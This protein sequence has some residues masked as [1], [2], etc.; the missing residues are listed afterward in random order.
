VDINVVLDLYAKYVGRTL[1]RAPVT[2]GKIVL[3]TTTPLTRTE[4]VQAL[5]A[6][7]ALNGISVVNIGEKFV[8]VLPSADA[9]TAAGEIDE[10]ASTN[11]PNLGSYITHVVQLKYVKPSEILP[12]IEPFS[13][14]KSNLAI[15]ANG[16]LIIRDYAENIKRMLEMV[17]RIDISVPAEYI[18]EVI[19]IRYAKVEDIASALTSLGGSG[20]SPVSIG[21]GGASPGGGGGRGAFGGGSRLGVSGGGG[22]Y[23][24][25]GGIGGGGGIGGNSLGG[26]LG[27]GGGAFGAQRG[28]GVG[29]AANPNGSPSGG[30]TFAQRL[31]N[32]INRAGASGGGGGGQDQIQLFG[33]TKIIPNASSSTLLVY[34]TRPDMKMIHEIIDKI[35]VP[36]AQVLIEALIVDVSLGSDFNFGISAKQNPK[37]LYNPNNATNILNTF[38]GAGGMNNG[39]SFLNF[40]TTAIGTNG[41]SSFGDSLG[42]FSYFGK[43]GSTWDAAISAANDD[44]RASI[45]Q[46]PRIQASQAQAANFQVG[47]S[48]PYVTSTY[49][50]YSGAPGGSSYS[51]LFAGVE[52]QVTPFINPDGLVVMDIGQTINEFSDFTEIANVGKVPNTIQRQLSSEIAVRDRDTVM[53]GGFIKSGKRVTKSGV[54][55]LMDIPIL[56]NLFT[57]RLDSKSRSELIVLMRPTVL[58]TPEIA[59][60]NTLKEE[61]RLPGVSAAAAEDAE[62]ERKL[63]D[64]QRKKEMSR[65][66]KTGRAD[67]FFN[68]NTDED[69]AFEKKLKNAATNSPAK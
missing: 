34:A 11:L 38:A 36:L 47:E 31:N 18:S 66:K 21:S 43:L 20:G 50:G 30:S 48:R 49:S 4:V 27:G 65:A 46:R 44:K 14:L 54:P 19:P 52:L 9:G 45:I 67:G 17:E 5:Q 32:I 69:N 64:A 10:S 33:Q 28:L 13:K 55:Y 60:Q 25:N 1:L 61:Q 26:G 22:G 59:A 68:Q 8:K 24:Q 40:L 12:A 39:S 53:L 29:G 7:L 35:D 37:T 57:S 42:A 6:V 15:D 41:A 23:G 63:I 62:Y 16:I 2:E 51:Q 56:G 58:R 3:K